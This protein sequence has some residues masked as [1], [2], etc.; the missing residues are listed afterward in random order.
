[1]LES[2][3]ASRGEKKGGPSR[4]RR[5]QSS[6]GVRSPHGDTFVSTLLLLFVET[7]SLGDVELTVAMLVK[8]PFFVGFNVRVIVA[9]PALAIVP[10][11]QTTFCECGLGAQL[12]CVELTEPNPVFFGIVSVT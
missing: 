3:R 11:L 2:L 10:M 12:P 6:K 9:V 5:N 4:A 1:M 7:G 8:R